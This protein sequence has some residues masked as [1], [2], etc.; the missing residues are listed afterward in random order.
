MTRTSAR[1]GRQAALLVAAGMGLAGLVTGCSAGQVTQ[2]DTQVA[3]VPGANASVGEV[4]LRDVLVP[5]DSPEGY[6]AGGNAPLSVRLFNASTRGDELTGVTSTGAKSVVLTTPTSSPRPQPCPAG[7]ASV[8]AP[9][10]PVETPPSAS[11]SPTPSGS[12]SASES[13]SPTPSA[14]ESEPGDAE[15]PG[16]TSFRV[17][18]PAQNGC[19]LLTPDHGAYLQLVNLN[20][21][22][23]PGQSVPVT[24]TFAEAGEITIEVPVGP[25]A[26]R[27]SRSPLDLH[28]GGEH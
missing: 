2:T 24:F 25:P 20:K 13:P 19:A 6:A 17:P 7:S 18:L 27:S 16:A 26:D 11:T 23:R 3:A 21:A 9:R 4:A 8:D 1:L 14:S 10:A 22:L 28:G 12:E 5:F 15:A